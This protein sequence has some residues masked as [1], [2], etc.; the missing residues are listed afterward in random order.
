METS[1][2]AKSTGWEIVERAV[3]AGLGSVPLVGNAIAVTFVT[4]VTWRLGQRREKWF[5]ELAETVEQLRCQID[6]LSL[7]SL[8]S[9][10]LFTDALVATTRTVERTHQAEKIRP[11]ATPC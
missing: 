11:S 2:P 4:A 6:G 7:E 1:P 8:T 3:E 10:N 9:N 5:T